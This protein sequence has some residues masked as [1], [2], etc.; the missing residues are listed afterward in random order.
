MPGT[1]TEGNVDMEPIVFHQM[2]RP[3]LRMMTSNRKE[4][5]FTQGTG[6]YE[7]QLTH[8]YKVMMNEIAIST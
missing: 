8:I 3:A 7:Y 5:A 4:P 1:S 6:T 2:T